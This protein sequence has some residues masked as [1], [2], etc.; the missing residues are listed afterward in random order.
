MHTRISRRAIVWSLVVLVKSVVDLDATILGLLE[1]VGSGSVTYARL[2]ALR[3]SLLG[4]T[5]NAKD[6]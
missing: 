3:R 4:P 5:R 6:E 2:A 1:E